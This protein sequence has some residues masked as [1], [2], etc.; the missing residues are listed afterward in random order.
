MYHLSTKYW[1]VTLLFVSTLV[2]GIVVLG[3]QYAY[4]ADSCTA[5]ATSYGTD[6][7][8][9]SLS[10][11]G[12]FTI[13]AHMEVP[14]T[15]AD[16]VLLNVNGTCYNVG[17][18]SSIPTNSWQWVNYYDG[19]S[20]NVMQQS[21]SQ[22]TQSILLTGTASGVR[23]DAVEFVPGSCTPSGNGSNCT[24]STSSSG[25]SGST[26]STGSSGST[27]G[28]TSSTSSAGTSGSS[29]S[30]T[31]NSQGHGV[32]VVGNNGTLTTTN[33]STPS[34]VSTPVT[35][36]PNAST[37][38]SSDPI[39]KVQYYLNKKLLDTA[40]AA[41]FTFHFDS[42]KY[43]NGTYTLTTKTTHRSGA[44]TSTSQKLI[45]KNPASFTQ[46]M[47]QAAH[48]SIYLFMLL[49]VVGAAIYLLLM[50][51]RNRQFTPE[52]QLPNTVLPVDPNAAT[53]GQSYP[54]PTAPLP[55]LPQP[56]QLLPTQPETPNDNPAQQDPGQQPR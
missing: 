36:Q 35:L 42:T 10:T 8:T 5:P 21:L 3:H 41:P 30:T 37:T 27:T 29:G 44:V 9:Q 38:G 2:M 14:S 49:I 24:T 51:L 40:T 17:G 45:I 28:S 34:Q 23:V 48:Y 47:L 54:E 13:W 33:T 56:Y 1:I 31:N 43:L 26:G 32:A 20:A 25:S 53:L 4:A 16:T 22:G 46:F 18:G 52:M 19:S 7:V 15:S 55:P 50:R 11:S 39:L 6:R 12:S